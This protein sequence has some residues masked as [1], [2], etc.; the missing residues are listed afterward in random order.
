MLLLHPFLWLLLLLLRLLWELLL[1]L[2]LR[3]DPLGQGH[4][5]LWRTI[6]APLPKRSFCAFR[7]LVYMH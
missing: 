3:L 7:T 1:L 2:L 5:W 6:Y 4:P